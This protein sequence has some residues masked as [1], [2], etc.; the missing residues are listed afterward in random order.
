VPEIKGVVGNIPDVLKLPYFHLVGY[1]AI[2]L[3]EANAEA[4]NAGFAGYNFILDAFKAP[5]FNF[6][7]AAMD[8]RKITFVTGQNSI[9]I[10]DETLT[11]LGPYFD[12]LLGAEQITPA[13]RAALEPYRKARQ[14]NANDFMT[15]TAAQ[16][17]GTIVGGNPQLI[18]GLTIPLGDQYVLLPSEQTEITE[19]TAAFNQI[20]AATVSS[21]D[22]IAFADVNAKYNQ[23]YATGLEISNGVS[24]TPT[25]P[26][27]T[28]VFSEDGVHV[29]SRG[30]AYTTNIFIDAINAKFGA[31]VPKANLAN[32]KATALPSNP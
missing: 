4:L 26:P 25:M 13:E 15:L 7:A 22:R 17:L 12:A 8:A 28:G 27:P 9:V 29:N 11:D 1:N 31:K 32:Y 10:T 16:I 20:I 5:P 14:A 23:F 24:V 6:P 18:N 21:L 3:P 2:P 30:M 19:R